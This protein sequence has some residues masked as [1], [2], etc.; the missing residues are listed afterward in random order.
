MRS[1]EFRRIVESL[2]VAIAMTDGAGAITFANHAFAELVG[3]EDRA[4]AGEPLQGLFAEDRKST[5][6]NSSH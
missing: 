2:K 3:R 4:L 6:L 5:R 1:A